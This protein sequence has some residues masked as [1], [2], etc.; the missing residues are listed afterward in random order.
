MVRR[1]LREEVRVRLHESVQKIVAQEGIEN[2]TTRKITSGC[3]FSDPYLYQCYDGIADLLESAFL[4][5]DR[6][7]GCVISSA[8]PLIQ[9]TSADRA[10]FEGGCKVLWLTCWNYLM[11][12]ANKTIFYWRFCQSGYRTA[13]I[14]EK[15]KVHHR[16]WRAFVKDATKR[17]RLDQHADV[18]LMLSAMVDNTLL[19]AVKV[20]RDEDNL[21]NMELSTETVFRSV[22]SQI[23]AIFEAKR[24]NTTEKEKKDA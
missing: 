3:G 17:H 11:K 6:E 5:I 1:F 18:E 16:D 2:L 8:I 22:F 9:F 7:I 4:E 13:D 19:S 21:A 24:Q 12:D 23:F 10:A 15:R 14:D 20:L